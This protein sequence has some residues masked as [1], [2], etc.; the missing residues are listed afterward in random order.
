MTSRHGKPCSEWTIHESSFSPW[1]VSAATRTGS[2]TIAPA[3]LSSGVAGRNCRKKSTATSPP[4][5][6]NV[7]KPKDAAPTS[8]PWR[9]SGGTWSKYSPTD[10]TCNGRYASVTVSG[11][12]GYAVAVPEPATVALLAA[13]LAS[14]LAYGLRLRKRCA[15]LGVSLRRG[16]NQVV[17]PEPPRPGKVGEFSRSLLTCRASEGAET[18]QG[19]SLRRHLAACSRFA[20]AEHP[21]RLLRCRG[22]GASGS[23][24]VPRKRSF[25]RTLRIWTGCR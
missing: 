3:G 6:N 7:G 9:Y 1:P 19:P 11:F 2:T 4:D 24:S 5:T 8:W 14:A 15:L 12:E 23:V 18:L 10:L 20:R 25:F 16:R 17:N 22:K 21:T 13:G